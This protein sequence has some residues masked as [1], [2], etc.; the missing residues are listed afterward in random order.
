MAA[1]ARVTLESPTGRIRLDSTR[2]A[3]APTYLVRDERVFW[4]TIYRRIDNVE[5]TF[6][7]Y[8][9]PTDPPPSQ[10]TP[11]CVKRTPPPWAR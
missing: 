5:H 8:F 3:I 6:G 9:K 2:T 11:A 10:A 4:P 7:G 1:L